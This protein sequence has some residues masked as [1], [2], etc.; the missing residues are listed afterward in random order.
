MFR[1]RKSLAARRLTAL[2]P[3]ELI[4]AWISPRKRS[5][6]D[7]DGLNRTWL[8]NRSVTR[9]QIK[10]QRGR[11]DFRSG[12]YNSFLTISGGAIADRRYRASDRHYVRAQA[13]RHEDL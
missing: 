5:A 8:D 12:N 1:L 13:M 10:P 7:L 9:I 2:C 3:R 6:R 11:P 4:T